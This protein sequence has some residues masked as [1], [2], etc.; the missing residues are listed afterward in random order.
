MQPIKKNRENL[1]QISIQSFG[2]QGLGNHTPVPRYKTFFIQCS[3]PSNVGI[4]YTQ[5]GHLIH[6]YTLHIIQT[7]CAMYER[8]TRRKEFYESLQLTEEKPL[9]AGIIAS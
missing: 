7:L 2:N 8:L 1:K 9:R 4:H 6:I 3:L 5:N